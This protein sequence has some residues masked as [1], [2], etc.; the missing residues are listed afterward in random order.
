MINKFAKIEET[1]NILE[2]DSL[3]LENIEKSKDIIIN[4]IKKKGK[5]LV[6][7]NGGSGTQASHM[8]GEFVGRFAFDRPALPAI[9]LFDLATT[10][11]VG[12]DYGYEDV[13]SRF[14]DG[15]GKK[16]DVLFS[17]STSGNSTNCL[18]AMKSAK[19]KGMLNI[20]LLGRDG[21]KMKGLADIAIVIPDDNTP[22]IQEVHLVVIHWLCEK[23]E[24]DF[25][26]K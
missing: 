10:T 2:K 21:G 11:A 22:L 9:S 18:K 7:G 26:G 12:N 15:L 23:I 4:S 16:N 14:V 6:C 25:F 5:L 3:F 13:F 19:R 24:L 17:I 20:A 1:L 8:V